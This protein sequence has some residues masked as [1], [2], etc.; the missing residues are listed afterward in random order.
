MVREQTLLLDKS[1]FQALSREEHMELF[2][3]YRLNVPPILV[4]EILS[5]LT[6]S[7]SKS[8]PELKVA[9]FARKFGGSG[10]PVNVDWNILCSGNL[11]G[12]FVEMRGVTVT[13]DFSEHTLPDGERAILIEP[14]P[15]NQAIMRWADGNFS[16]AE[17]AF[18]ARWRQRFAQ[19]STNALWQRLERRRIVVPRPR[20]APDVIRVVD[21]LLA[22]QSLHDDLVTYL[23]EQV[24]PSPE[25]VRTI[26][27]RWS[28]MRPVGLE[29]F[30]PY[31][32]HC[33]RAQLCVLVATRHRLV[34]PEA[35]DHLD[36]QYL[37]YL[38]FCHCF[39]SNDRLHRLLAPQL[40]NAEQSFVHGTVLKAQ[41]REARV[42]RMSDR[43]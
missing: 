31:A 18:A 23:V 22:H 35:K 39:S 4:A 21:Q 14:G 36:A 30:A 38:P 27:A 8:T 43:T 37:Y 20:D 40:L 5:D 11:G 6:R 17:R 34:R 15:L 9:E 7:F 16:A 13:R 19:M 32:Y 24:R 2:K 25:G 33:L 28:R 26:T 41:L 42:A 29:S 3:R 1:A 10:D 12:E